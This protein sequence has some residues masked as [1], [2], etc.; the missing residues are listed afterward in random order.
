MHNRLNFSGGYNK[1]V[2][3]WEDYKFNEE[4]NE[5]E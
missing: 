4:E 3:G 2:I 1:F 5:L